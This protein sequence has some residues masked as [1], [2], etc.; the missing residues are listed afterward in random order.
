MIQKVFSVKKYA[1]KLNPKET[2]KVVSHIPDSQ[3]MKV[4]R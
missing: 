4:R 2:V 1:G 3:G